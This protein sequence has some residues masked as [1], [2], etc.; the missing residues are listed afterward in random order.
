M[1]LPFIIPAIYS[2]IYFF[3]PIFFCAISHY[4][5]AKTAKKELFAQN[6]SVLFCALGSAYTL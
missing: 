4:F 2:S 3:L 6:N 1:A 5:A